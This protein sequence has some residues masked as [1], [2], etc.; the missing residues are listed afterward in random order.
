MENVLRQHN[1][2]RVQPHQN[3]VL[4][5]I[6]NDCRHIKYRQLNVY[7]NSTIMQ[8]GLSLKSERACGRAYKLGVT[9]LKTILITAL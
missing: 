7:Q 1:I 9:A 6:L 2:K 4:L 5:V 3:K 8:R